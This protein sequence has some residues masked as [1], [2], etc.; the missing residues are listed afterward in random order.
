[1]K[2]WMPLRVSIIALV[3]SV[4]ALIVNILRILQ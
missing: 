3:T 1:M 4:I 2:K